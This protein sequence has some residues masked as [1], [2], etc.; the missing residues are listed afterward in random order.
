MVARHLQY[1]FLLNAYLRYAKSLL[2]LIQNFP[3]FPPLALNKP[4]LAIL[5]QPKHHA[6]FYERGLYQNAYRE[7]QD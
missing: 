7:H 2:F 5:H 3:A 1:V 6:F 4:L